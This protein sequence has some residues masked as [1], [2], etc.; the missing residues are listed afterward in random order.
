MLFAGLTQMLAW[1]Q[2]PAELQG[3]EVLLEVELDAF[4]GRPNPRWRLTEA[5]AAEFLALF[6]KLPPARVRAPTNG[7]LGYRGFVLRGDGGTLAG[8][9]EVRIDRGVVLARRAN[10]EEMFSDPQLDLERWLLASARGHVDEPVLKY[11][12]SEITR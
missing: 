4:S 8:F 12:Q 3:R 6:H 5:Q 9:D 10:D 7:G 1:G 2:P 11:L